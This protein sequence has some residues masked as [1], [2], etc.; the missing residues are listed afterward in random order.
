MC[1][2]SFHRQFGQYHVIFNRDE[3]PERVALAGSLDRTEV[4][5]G[6]TAVMPWVNA[7]RQRSPTSWLG[8]NY[9]L[10]V[11]LLNRNRHGDTQPELDSRQSRG[12]LVPKALTHLKL[13][14]VS[15][16]L[17]KPKQ[18]TSFSPCQL[19]VLNHTG[20]GLI[21]TWAG[22]GSA[23][24][25]SIQTLAEAMSEQGLSN[26]LHLASCG[27]QPGGDRLA[28]ERIKFGI[29]DKNVVLEWLFWS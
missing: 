20:E 16:E 3:H 2:F 29:R 26:R 18:W 24:G 14:G 11:Y 7:H 1:T 21:F 12:Y 8:A 19:V 25:L 27:A 28:E 13:E 4:G 17:S 9:G 10:S 6:I 22:P 23:A 15:A 5:F